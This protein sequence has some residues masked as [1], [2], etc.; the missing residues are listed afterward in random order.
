[1]TITYFQND[2]RPY[3]QPTVTID[4]V[5]EDMSSGFTFEVNIALTLATEPVLTKTTGIAGGPDGLVVVGW[6]VGDLDVDP[7]TYFV[8]LTATRTSDSK[9]WTIQDK[10]KIKQR[11]T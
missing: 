10:I 2:E 11:L 6:A 3:W 5:A 9:D 4:G 1:M 7:G 8:Q